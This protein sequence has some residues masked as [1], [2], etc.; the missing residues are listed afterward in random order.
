MW[1][2]PANNAY[3][4]VKVGACGNVEFENSFDSGKVDID[5][6]LQSNF[7]QNNTMQKTLKNI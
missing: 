5:K 4:A 7:E 2:D 6:I 3:E 1:F